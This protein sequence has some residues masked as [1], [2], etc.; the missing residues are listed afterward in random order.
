[1]RCRLTTAQWYLSYQSNSPPCPQ[2]AAAAA[3]TTSGWRYSSNPNTFQPQY[4]ST[5]IRFNPNLTLELDVTSATSPSRVA[6]T[7]LIGQQTLRLQTPGPD[8]GTRSCQRSGT[9]RPEA[10]P[11]QPHPNKCA[12]GVAQCAR[13][14]GRHQHAAP[15]LG[16]SHAG[17]CGGTWGSPGGRGGQRLGRSR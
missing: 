1:M 16:S 3:G 14:D 2:A 8:T 10:G 17:D 15:S 12:Q 9:Q 6:N 4:I 7:R 13:Q 11:A 5:P